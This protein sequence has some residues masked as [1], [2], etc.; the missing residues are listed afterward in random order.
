MPKQAA[1]TSQNKLLLKTLLEFYR[2]NEALDDVLSII[3]G[4]SPISLRVVDWFATNYSK[5]NFVVIEHNGKRVNVYTDYK[6]NLRAYSKRR[7]DPFCRW[8]RITIPYKDGKHIQ[9][10]IGQLN[11]FRW[12]IMRGV[13]NF[14]K[15]NLEAIERDMNTRNSTSR[16][17]SKPHKAIRKDGTR[18]RREELSLYAAKSIHRDQV[19]VTVKFA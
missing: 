13:I 1:R 16:R 15:P 10:T 8:D 9:T 5:Q 17:K 12:A 4:E 3:N 18:K 2:D 14:I 19:Q 7:F 6:L 11:F